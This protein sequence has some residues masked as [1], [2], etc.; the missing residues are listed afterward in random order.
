MA[1]LTQSYLV[2]T[3]PEALNAI[4][5][6]RFSAGQ[7][8]VDPDLF[9]AIEGVLRISN[10]YNFLDIAAAMKETLARFLVGSPEALFRLLA[11][12]NRTLR[13]SLS[14]P[15]WR[16]QP[17]TF[18][19]FAHNHRIP[20]LLPGI[21][22]LILSVYDPNELAQTQEVPAVDKIRCLTGFPGLY[23]QLTSGNDLLKEGEGRNRVFWNFVSLSR[24][25][26]QKIWDSLPGLFRLGTWEDL[27]R[28][29]VS[30][31]VS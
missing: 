13:G 20:A 6:W 24:E 12:L 2:K 11:R 1:T 3:L 4:G 14:D 25:D 21:Y 7:T 26:Q 22:Y 17:P 19:K 23:A 27:K 5:S 29:V 10:K 31:A 15:V 28:G 16:Y 9:P 30:T 8:V 18:L